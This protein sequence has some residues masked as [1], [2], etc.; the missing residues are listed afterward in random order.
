MSF[1]PSSAF[2]LIVAAGLIVV[3]TAGSAAEPDGS[4][5]DPGQK[6]DQESGQRAGRGLWFSSRGPVAVDRAAVRYVAADTGGI[7]A[8][9]FVFERVLAFEARLLALTEGAEGYRPRHVRAAL[10]R[11]IA[12]TL[13]AARTLKPALAEAEL[14]QRTADAQIALIERV[15]GPEAYAAALRAEGLEPSEARR[16]LRTRA[17]ASLHMDRMNA[18][19]LH[20]DE[21]ELRVLHRAG[22]T[23]FSKRE[24]E[25][26]RL[27]L[28]RWLVS[29]RVDA[30]L[31]D[32]FR[33][34]RGRVSVHWL[35]RPK[36]R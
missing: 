22:N 11:H 10:E 26:A 24:F 1:R 2:A 7:L 3:T 9:Q 35:P 31:D 23:P 21:A 13:L 27:P 12:E 14:A 17:R 18:Q 33:A 19:I 5:Q 34:A 6:S 28:K 4:G 32:F 8:P 29:R 36:H 25:V 30:A 20:P 16:L 15:G